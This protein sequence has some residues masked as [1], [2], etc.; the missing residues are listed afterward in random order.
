LDFE[1]DIK[2]N[3]VAA[4]FWFFVGLV[5]QSLID[6]LKPTFLQI[7]PSLLQRW[8]GFIAAFVI[9][10]LIFAILTVK[11]SP[12]DVQAY[13][14]FPAGTPEQDMTP[15]FSRDHHLRR[16][17]VNFKTT[18][19]TAFHLP[20]DSYGW[21]YIQ[22]HRERW[23]SETDTAP[24]DPKFLETWCREH[25]YTF[26]PIVASRRSL[27]VSAY[28]SPSTMLDPRLDHVEYRYF[29]P[30]CRLL[31]PRST[32]SS[33]R[34]VLNW[35]TYRAWALDLW[36]LEYAISGKIRGTA[37]FWWPSRHYVQKWAKRN[38][39]EWSEKLPTMEDLLAKSKEKLTSR[40]PS[41]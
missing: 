25:G 5:L 20:V 19:P 27:I 40:E 37:L 14:F 24:K 26:V 21:K 16:T 2:G 29:Y 4:V 38:G 39:F 34:C 30:P 23:V 6:W 11:P 32:Y 12:T 1:F 10:F 18:P 7:L 9:V 36:T 3:F 28:Y 15:D 8:I 22:K 33:K 13:L 35:S 17:I 41:N 31:F